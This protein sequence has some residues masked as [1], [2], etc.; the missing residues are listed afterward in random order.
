MLMM[1]YK[2]FLLFEPQNAHQTV[3]EN[4]KSLDLHINLYSL[5][6]VAKQQARETHNEQINP[7]QQNF[8]NYNISCK[9][10]FIL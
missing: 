2:F 10:N 5:L 1:E 3:H 7:H 6:M 4:N 8:F 9:Y